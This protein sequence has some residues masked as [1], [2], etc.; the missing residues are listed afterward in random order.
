MA[1]GRVVSQYE[2]ST[3][4]RVGRAALGWTL[5]RLSTAS[6]ISTATLYKLE[7]GKYVHEKTMQTV[8]RAIRDAGVTFHRA[9][10]GRPSVQWGAP[11][12]AWQPP[13]SGA[14]LAEQA[15]HRDQDVREHVHLFGRQVDACDSD[16]EHDG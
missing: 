8:L 10:D 1:A 14:R 3:R 16:G 11:Q 6:G 2:V 7:A 9:A 4:I 12:A 5:I 13:L 15:E